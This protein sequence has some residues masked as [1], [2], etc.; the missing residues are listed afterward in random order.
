VLDIG[1]VLVLNCA[2]LVS[3]AIVHVVSAGLMLFMLQ[4]VLV[5]EDRFCCKALKTNWHLEIAPYLTTSPILQAG[6]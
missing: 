1:F 4:P 6:P 3:A 2:L 5:S